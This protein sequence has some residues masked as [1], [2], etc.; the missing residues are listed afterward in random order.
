LILFGVTDRGE[1]VGQD[2]STRTLEEIAVELR[3]IEPPAFREIETI[4]LANGKTVLALRVPGGG[5]PYTYDGRPFV[6]H[7]PTTAVMPNAEHERRIME[8]LHATHRWENQP[9]AGGVTIADLDEVESGAR[10][11][12]R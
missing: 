11:R 7:G 8:R 6:R 3:R 5:G 10:W 12:T 2:V 9:V 4:E 1:I